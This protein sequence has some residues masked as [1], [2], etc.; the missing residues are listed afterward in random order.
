[1]EAEHVQPEP[2]IALRV[3]AAGR[4]SVTVTIPFVG[5]AEGPLL[6]VKVYVAPV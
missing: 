3:R 1:V 6:T 2:A 5:P 4:I